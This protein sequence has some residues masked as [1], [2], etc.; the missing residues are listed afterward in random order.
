M[1]WPVLALLL[2]PA[3]CGPVRWVEDLRSELRCG[4]SLSE[5]RALTDH[6]VER[7]EPSNNTLPW[8]GSY[9]IAGKHADVWLDFEHDQLVSF[10][11]ARIDGLTSMR[12]SPKENLCSLTVA[13]GPSSAGRASA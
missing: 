10:I 6:E 13:P 2:L 3:S 4:V 9:L 1:K 7:V 8:R 5:L 11:S 12:S